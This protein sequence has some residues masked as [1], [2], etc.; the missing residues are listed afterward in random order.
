MRYLLH[1]LFL[2][3][4]E[5]FS[6]KTAIVHEDGES[7]TYKDLK[8]RSNLYA[9]MMLRSKSL[10]IGS[11]HSTNKLIGI[12][13]PVCFDSVAF[14]LAVLRLGYAYVPLDDS[15]PAERISKIIENSG[16]RCIGTF[17]Q[18]VSTY[19]ELFFRFHECDWIFLDWGTVNK[20]LYPSALNLICEDE[21]NIIEPPI[22][23]QVSDD[24]AYILH[25]SGSTGIPKGIMLTHRNARTFTDWMQKEF[26]LT[27]SDLVM[28]RAPFK[29]DLSVFDIFNTIGT[30]ATLV[31]FNWNK[32]RIDSISRHRDYVQLMKTRAA[33]ILY[34]TP[35]TLITLLNKGGL[36]E[37]T[38]LRT[39]MYAGEPF[40]VPQ[41][42]N[43]IN[44]MPY[45]KI[46]NIYG[47]T[48]TNIIT[49]FWIENL[50]ESLES[51]PLGLVVDDTE[52]LIVA[53][54]RQRICEIDE[55]GELWCRGGTVTLGYLGMD[56]KNK[57]CLIKSPFH[58]YPAYYWRTG[59]FGRRDSLGL[60]HYHGRR[61]HMVKVRGFRIELGEIENALSKVEGIHQGIVV[62]IEDENYGNRL[63]CYYSE[64]EQNTID[65]TKVIESLKNSLPEYMLPYA[66][67][68]MLQLPENSSGKI[69]RVALRDIA[70]KKYKI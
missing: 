25:T 69:D 66:V 37:V 24:L 50:P 40:P 63:I 68:K 49:Y 23:N 9:S 3:T 27:S 35:S 43:L 65:P 39:I 36:E 47:P 8:N 19:R 58:T 16:I 11:G 22:L 33:S 2:Q 38:T 45:T 51:I 1:D 15:S 62:A 60:L 4:V 7:F 44:K 70:V 61:D 26:A 56:D 17:S 32:P 54:D 59:D 14:V 13:G 53:D 12:L 10:A 29:F 20:T 31:C 6:E 21:V 5:N 41:L 46:A 28:S 34:T 42:R 67:E 55:I 64:I 52:I 48:E 18:Q 30:G 57:E